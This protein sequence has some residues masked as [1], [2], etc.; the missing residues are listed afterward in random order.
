MQCSIPISGVEFVPVGHE[1]GL[2]VVDQSAQVDSVV[3]V[4]GKVLDLAIWQHRLEG[5][6]IMR[7]MQKLYFASELPSAKRA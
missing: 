2:A 4:A 5:K 6:I 7:S 1:T 3:P